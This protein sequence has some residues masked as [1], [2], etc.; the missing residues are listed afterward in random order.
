MLCASVGVM[1]MP[2]VSRAAGVQTESLM[3]KSLTGYVE[4]GEVDP[5]EGTV[6][7]AYI[8]PEAVTMTATV[9][10]EAVPIEDGMIHLPYFGTHVVVVT[11][12]AAGYATLTVT[13]DDVIWEPT[14]DDPT[15]QIHVEYLE[16][17]VVVMATGLGTISLCCNGELVDNPCIIDYEDEEM[18]YYFAAYS[19]YNDR[20]ED[21]HLEVW[22]PAK[23]PV[24]YEGHRIVLVDK[25]G[26]E[27]R[28]DLSI[29]AAGDYEIL[30]NLYSTIYGD[31]NLR[32]YFEAD[33]LVYGASGSDTPV[34]LGDA[35]KNPTT[36]YNSTSDEGFAY[37]TVASGYSYLLALD[38]VY[39]PDTFEI[40]D[41][42]ILASRGGPVVSNDYKLGD[43]DGNKV[44]G[45]DDLTMLIDYLLVGAGDINRYNTDVDNDGVIDIN[46][47]TALI[48][49][50]L[51]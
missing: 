29:N 18:W 48:D 3:T 7:V 6:S 32:F 12:K 19:V 33:D 16:N 28:F 47:V 51:N 5:F 1:F 43:V 14:L 2:Q 8:G 24:N 15:L 49:L 4:L 44:L 11:V 25:F 10:G 22:V 42:N 50:L 45:I 13:F 17:G 39:D 9:N 34:Y 20:E 21:A 27:K 35:S 38:V 40:A 37:F 36:Q 23:E 41:Y 31:G 46:D 26:E 30:I